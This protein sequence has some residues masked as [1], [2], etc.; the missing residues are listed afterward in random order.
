MHQTICPSFSSDEALLMNLRKL[1]SITPIDQ[2]QPPAQQS[3]VLE[4]FNLL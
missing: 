3:A 2:L 1:S 4:P